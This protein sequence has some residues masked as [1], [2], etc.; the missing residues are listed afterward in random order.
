MLS[1]NISGKMLPLLHE[2]GDNLNSQDLVL[3]ETPLHKAVK[4][5][6]VDNFKYLA[7]HKANPNLQDV[8]GE[9]V[10]HKAVHITKAVQWM[11]LMKLGGN[12]MTKNC[13]GQTPLEKA[14]RAKN[15]LAISV[16]NECGTHMT[17]RHSSFF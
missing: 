6:M 9:T 10:L 3:S 15:A 7:K 4:H 8:I 13:D 14:S 1:L 12:M 5:Q 16:M 2:H 11:T 17:K